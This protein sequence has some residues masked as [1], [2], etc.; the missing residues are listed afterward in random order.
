MLGA[1][2]PVLF[3]L[4]AIA[5]LAEAVLVACW[6]VSYVIPIELHLTLHQRYCLRCQDGDWQWIVAGY[7]KLIRF[8]VQVISTSPTL[9][10]QVPVEET[11]ARKLAMQYPIPRIQFAQWPCVQRAFAVNQRMI[12]YVGAAI[13]TRYSGTTPEANASAVFVTTPVIMSAT[14][15][16]ACRAWATPCWLPLSCASAIALLIFWRLNVRAREE[17]NRQGRCLIC[18]YDLRA[19]PDRCP[20]CGTAPARKV[21]T[22][23]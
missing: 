8:N 5:I 13:I 9:S 19:T 2:T 15:G 22:S 6:L 21:K 4:F 14:S 12:P 16:I 20:E 11:D 1:A 10:K 23:T 18:G 3:G 7:S 17:L